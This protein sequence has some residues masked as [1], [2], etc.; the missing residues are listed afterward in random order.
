[1]DQIISR[2]GIYG[3]F[4]GWVTR[5]GDVILVVNTISLTGYYLGLLGPHMMAILKAR[6]AAALI[7]ETID[8]VRDIEALLL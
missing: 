1:M 3:Y 7:Y 6:I 2:V 5:G 8:K 4:N